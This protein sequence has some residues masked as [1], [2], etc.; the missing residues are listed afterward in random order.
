[1]SKNIKILVIG[2]GVAGPAVCYWLRRFGF[3][4]VLIEKYASIRKGGQALDVRGIATHI[5][6]EMGIYD[7]ICEMR[8]R[9]E[10]GRFVD[11]SGKVLHEEQGEKFGFRQDDEVEILRGDLVEILMKTIADVPCY[12]NQS[13]ISIEQNA[14][15]VT[16]IF[17]DG[18]IEQY[19][20]V[21]AADGIHS[22]IRRMIFE[23][24]EYQLIHLGAYLST[25]TIPNYLGLSHIDLECEA[26]NKLVSINSDNNPEIAR[27]GFMFRSQHLLN[28]IRDEQEQ[29]QFLRD[30]FRDFGWETQ[31]IL[32]RMPESNDF[33]FDAITQVKM[34]SWTK[35]RIALVGDAGYCPSPLS[36][37]GNNLAFVGAYILAGELKVANG[38][39]TRA[40]TRYN[41]LLRSFVDA[42]QKFGV[43]VS[44]SFLVKDEVSKEI[45]EERSNKILAMI[46]SISN[47]I[48][49]PQ[50]ESS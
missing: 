17:M 18:R 37:Q 50:Y 24:N 48:T 36:G 9:I 25:F 29:K 15:N 4:P 27:A 10:R 40:F 22:A 14:D 2:A 44:E 26:N 12:F 7:Q 8:T 49:L 6:R 30:T 16:V 42:N 32:N 28:D 3:S 38:N 19:D 43:W 5:A 41:A 23:K 39:Y 35:G 1:M 21:I 45:A 47:G 33:Y 31:N 20:L 34:N 11:S 46:K 13:I